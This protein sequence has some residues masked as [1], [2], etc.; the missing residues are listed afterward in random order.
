MVHT[1]A[2]TF[3]LFCW[4]RLHLSRIQND[5]QT[6]TVDEVDLFHLQSFT[7]LNNSKRYMLT[8]FDKCVT[9]HMH[10]LHMRYI[11]AYRKL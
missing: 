3:F 5:D 2:H 8:M 4:L 9:L 7:F 1:K 10:L 11:S 6:H